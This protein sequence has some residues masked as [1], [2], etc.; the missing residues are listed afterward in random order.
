MSYILRRI[1]PSGTVTV[2]RLG[3]RQVLGR[4]TADIPIRGDRFV[5]GQHAEVEVTGDHVVLRDLDSRNGTFVRLE[6]EIELRHGDVVSVGRQL[7]RYLE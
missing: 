4:E 1:D 7:L 2:I 6:S 3:E 5:S